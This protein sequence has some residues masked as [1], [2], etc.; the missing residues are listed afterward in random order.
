MARILLTRV[1][2]T[3]RHPC[4]VARWQGGQGEDPLDPLQ[5]HL[6]QD[7][8]EQRHVQPLTPRVLVRRLHYRLHGVGLAGMD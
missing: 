5:Q 3:R 8:H 2:I 6:L 1:H 4:R 7:G